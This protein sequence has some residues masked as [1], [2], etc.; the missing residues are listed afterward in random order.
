MISEYGIYK[1]N[2][3]VNGRPKQVIIDDIFPVF[4]DNTKRLLF[5]KE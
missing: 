1:L 2:I 3:S 4:Q 5:C